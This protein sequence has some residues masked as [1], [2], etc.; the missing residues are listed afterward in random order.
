MTNRDNEGRALQH[1]TLVPICR[2]CGKPRY[3]KHLEV[4]AGRVPETPCDCPPG[5]QHDPDCHIVTGE[6]PHAS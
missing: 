2:L 4:C 5:F 3:Q 1:A 6:H